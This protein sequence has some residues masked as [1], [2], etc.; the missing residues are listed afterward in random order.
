MARPDF[1][2]LTSLKIYSIKFGKLERAR[3]DIVWN[4]YEYTPSNFGNDIGPGLIL[5]DKHLSKSTQSSFEN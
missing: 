5:S 4:L 1:V 3:P 2:G